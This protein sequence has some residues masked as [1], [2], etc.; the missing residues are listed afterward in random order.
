MLRLLGHDRLDHALVGGHRVCDGMVMHQLVTHHKGWLHEDPHLGE[1]LIARRLQQYL[2]E[3]QVRPCGL[4]R[5]APTCLSH[6]LECLMQ[7]SHVAV[8]AAPGGERRG[9]RLD[10]R[11]NLGQ[12]SEDCLGVPARLTPSQNIAV[13]GVP[14]GARPDEGASLLPGV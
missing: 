11:T 8:A 9:L 3:Y 14:F 12:I 7:R 2:V 10:G 13:Q 1:E 6:P 4:I 5:R